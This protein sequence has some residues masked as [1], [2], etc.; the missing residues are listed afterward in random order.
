MLSALRAR[1][2]H[3]G[4]FWIFVDVMVHVLHTEMRELYALEDLWGD[5]KQLI[6]RP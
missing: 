3:V 2:R 1:P 5:A 4:L 6:W